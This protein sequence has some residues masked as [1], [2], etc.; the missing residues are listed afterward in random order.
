MSAAVRP[1][2]ELVS[3]GA[4]QHALSMAYICER[5]AAAYPP[6]RAA[7]AGELR[8]EA[9]GWRSLAA[10]Q[11]PG[12]PTDEQLERLEAAGADEIR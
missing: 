11:V 6:A 12:S 5:R 9:A 8:D 10:G 7:E 4:R 1:R 2:V 3:D